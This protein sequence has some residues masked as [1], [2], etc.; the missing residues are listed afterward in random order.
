M[1]RSERFN[2]PRFVRRVTMAAALVLIAGVVAFT[3]AFFGNTAE[4]ESTPVRP[5]AG[6]AAAQPS[7]AGAQ[8]NQRSV[9]L[10]KKA[11]TV[12]GKFILSAVTREDMAAAWKITDPESDI[13]KCGEAPCTYKEWLTG[14]VPIQV[15]PAEELDDATFAIHESLPG[16]AVLQVA[17]LPKDGSAMKGQ[18]FYVGL[19]KVGTGSK[20]KW[21]VT[22]WAPHA[23]NP[24]PD[25]GDTH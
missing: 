1:A 11:T 21:L 16:L 24:V 18:V 5:A 14:N 7:A 2:S 20:A 25:T 8:A 15:F 9:P 6:Q 13:R 23:I 3:I 12:A 19:R 10:D 17:L 22:Y 4:D